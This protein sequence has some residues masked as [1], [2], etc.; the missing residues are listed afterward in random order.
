MKV[1]VAGGTGFLGRH[2][3]RSLM[4]GGHEVTVMG[5]DP[6][7]VSRIP[8]LAGANATRG[9]V[10][11]PASLRGTTEGADAVV[12]SVGFP[13]YPIEQPRKGLTFDRFDRQGT[14]NLL[15]EAQR[16]GVERFFYL[17]GAAVDP[18]SDKSWYRA[19][20]R[21]EEAIKT[22]GISYAILRPSW[23]YGPE[24]K[25]LNKFVSIARFSPIVP[26]P[27]VKKQR[28][29]P[30]YCGDIALAAQRIFER[31]DAWDRTLE[32]GGP[33]MT[34]DEIVRTMLDVMGKRRLVVPVPAP[35]LKLLTAPLNV[36]PTPPMNPGGI[37]FAVQEGLVD[38]TEMEQ[39]LDVHPI[40][41][42]QGLSHYLGS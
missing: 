30:V 37:D 16:S 40:T 2:I 28:V 8:Q 20:G 32:I 13:N 35:L 9:D 18:D 25:A 3:S 36:L 12:F 22:G 33:V 14:E 11:D 23:A 10:T 41:L 29:Q 34:M 38:T 21:A 42:R 6:N 31:D 15:A 17:S 27:G 5:R 19:K 4:D 1:V 7:K 26:K 39:V 24:D